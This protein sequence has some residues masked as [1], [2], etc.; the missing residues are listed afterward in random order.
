MSYACRFYAF[1]LG[2]TVSVRDLDVKFLAVYGDAVFFV[3]R[4]FR[5]RGRRASFTRICGF[6]SDIYLAFAFSSCNAFFLAC[7]SDEDIFLARLDALFFK[8]LARKFKRL[9]LVFIRDIHGVLFG[10][11]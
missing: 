7:R 4:S 1:Y 3:Y 11:L 5:A 10:R 2:F 8:Q 9:A 6:F